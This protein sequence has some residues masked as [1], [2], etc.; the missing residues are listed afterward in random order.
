MWE[1]I[2]ILCPRLLLTSLGSGVKGGQSMPEGPDFQSEGE[3]RKRSILQFVGVLPVR[4]DTEIRTKLSSLNCPSLFLPFP[5][6][7][8]V[9]NKAAWNEA[10]GVLC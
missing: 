7:G 1:A 5:N 2:Q 6:R 8:G 3:L 9:P 4:E 10:G